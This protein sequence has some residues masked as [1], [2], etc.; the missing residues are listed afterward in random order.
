MQKYLPC[1]VTILCLAVFLMQGGCLQDYL[2]RLLQQKED[3]QQVLPDREEAEQFAG[4]MEKIPDGVLCLKVYFLEEKGNY[5]LPVTVTLPWSEGVGRAALEKLIEGPTPAQ[6]MRYGI[7]SPLPPTT[8]ILGLAIR[9]GQ[10]KVDL[11]ESFL[12]YDPGKEK[13]VLD[14]VVFTL[15]QFPTIKEVQLLVEGTVPGIFPGGTPGKGSFDRELRINSEIAE[16][17]APLIDSRTVTLY[18]CSVL[19]ENNIFYVPVSRSAANNGDIV[20]VTLKE[21]LKGPRSDSFLFSELPPGTELLGSTLK[22]NILTVN[23]SRE[24]LNYKGGLSGEKNICAQIL[25]TLTELP[26][27]E[28]V[29]LLVE[30]EKKTLSYGTSFQ[31]PLPRPLLVNPII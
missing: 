20:Q 9:E 27:V 18:F 10:A 2:P 23:F 25:L 6:E 26:G 13:S 8:E 19:G 21:L 15:L 7:C 31:N 14:S 12:S 24:I 4:E 29:Q 3:P 11:S 5:L 16:G 22:D 17:A 28:K 1:M 30:G